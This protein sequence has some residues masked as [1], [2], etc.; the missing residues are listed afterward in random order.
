MKKVRYN[1]HSKQKNPTYIY[2]VFRYNKQE[3]RYCTPFTVDPAHWKDSH[4]RCLP[5]APRAAITNAT[6]DRMANVIE[7]YYYKSMFTRQAAE[8]E[9][10]GRLLDELLIRKR[11]RQK[12][13]VAEDKPTAPIDFFAQLIEKRRNDPNFTENTLR[14]HSSFLK[15]LSE[16]QA[17]QSKVLNWHHFTLNFF[18]DLTLWLYSKGHNQNTVDKRINILNAWLNVARKHEYP[19]PQVSYSVG[20][21]E[22][23]DVYFTREELNK[24]ENVTCNDDGEKIALYRFL[25]GCYTGLRVSDFSTLSINKFVKRGESEYIEH[26]IQKSGKTIKVL[27]PVHYKIKN[28]FREF[29]KMPKITIE[30]QTTNRYIKVLANRAGITEMTTLVKNKQGKMVEITK[31]KCDWVSTHTARRTFI[32]NAFE[33]SVAIDTIMAV[34]GIKK[35]QTLMKYNKLEKEKSADKLSKS[36]YFK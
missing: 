10:M 7:E 13:V 22:I 12:N 11:K 19:V 23:E 24:L 18:E 9:E 36:D 31:P 5:K 21:I 15:L 16:F 25:I 8:K 30:D 32:T 28:I 26:S 33:S 29:A 20:D 34:T 4:Q 27:I 1:L 6:L 14:G 35:I 2:L 17:T 3:F